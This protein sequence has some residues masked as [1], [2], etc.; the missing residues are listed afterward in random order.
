MKKQTIRS[1]LY[2]V[3]S[4]ILVVCLTA[5]N[6]STDVKKEHSDVQTEHVAE[7][8]AETFETAEESERTDSADAESTAQ[9]EATTL[10]EDDKQEVAHGEVS[11]GAHFLNKQ[12]GAGGY[13]RHL[14]TDGEVN[15]AAD[16]NE[17]DAHAGDDIEAGFGDD[18]FE[19]GP[20]KEEGPADYGEKDY[21]R[22]KDNVNG[23]LAPCVA[24]SAFDSG[25]S[26]H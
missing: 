24:E 9:Q 8:E 20:G 22:N 11:V 1:V 21:K 3:A 15:T 2:I 17:G 19:V 16:H 4:V 26:F 6:A 12:I 14:I 13:H 23:A 5:C 10:S 7:A 18:V 25:I